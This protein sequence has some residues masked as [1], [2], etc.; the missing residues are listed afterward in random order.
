[1]PGLEIN[2]ASLIMNA[3]FY[4]KLDPEVKQALHVYEVFKLQCQKDGHTFLFEA[5]V[6]RCYKYLLGNKKKH[7]YFNLPIDVEF[8]LFA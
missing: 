2:L 6:K 4:L 1:M 7:H 8:R 3:P 5:D